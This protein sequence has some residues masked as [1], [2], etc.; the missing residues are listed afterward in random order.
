MEVFAQV[1]S[2]GE[3]VVVSGRAA[4]KILFSTI[5]LPP[6]LLLTNKKTHQ[7]HSNRFFI[8]HFSNFI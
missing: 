3:Q 6:S 5:S 1:N 2:R 8:F 7:S 4:W